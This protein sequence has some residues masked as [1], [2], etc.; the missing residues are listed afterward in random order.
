MVK[1]NE[2][3]STQKAKATEEV[4]HLEQPKHFELKPLVSSL[5]IFVPKVLKLQGKLFNF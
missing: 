5:T 4:Y 1:L 2:K 3:N